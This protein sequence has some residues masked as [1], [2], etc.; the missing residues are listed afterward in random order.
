[1][2]DTI[3]YAR[4]EACPIVSSHYHHHLLHR[5][6]S[7]PLLSQIFL[8]VQI[9]PCRKK[10]ASMNGAWNF[11]SI[12]YLFTPN[13]L[14]SS[15][16]CPFYSG[17]A[18]CP[19]LISDCASLNVFAISPCTGLQIHRSWMCWNRHLM[20]LM[21]FNFFVLEH[22]WPG[23]QDWWKQRHPFLRFCDG[24]AR[25]CNSF[26]YDFSPL[27]LCL[28][29]CMVSETWDFSHKLPFF[30]VTSLTEYKAS[31]RFTNHIANKCIHNHNLWQSKLWLIVA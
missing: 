4:W 9:R 30:K 29:T 16:L 22:V 12:K 7:L 17:A 2:L 10:I 18:I 26:G 20:K 28:M 5:T 31:P 15:E 24:D 25:V 3:T 23:P 8:S 1:M 14:R 11:L 13:G 27:N 21:I 6:L 19:K